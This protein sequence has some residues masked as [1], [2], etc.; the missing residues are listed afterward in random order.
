M[1]ICE[2]QIEYSNTDR[3]WNTEGYIITVSNSN[4]R[5]YLKNK[6]WSLNY[7]YP[8]VVSTLK[9]TSRGSMISETKQ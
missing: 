2:Y 1:C 8:D 6:N 3:V 7:I 4:N 5:T 9:L